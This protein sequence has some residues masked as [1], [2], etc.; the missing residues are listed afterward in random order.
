MVVGVAG[1]YLWGKVQ[2]AAPCPCSSRCPPPGWRGSHCDSRDHEHLPANRFALCPSCATHTDARH[3][4]HTPLHFSSSLIYSM[5]MFTK[6]CTLQLRNDCK[7]NCEYISNRYLYLL[8]LCKVISTVLKIHLD[9]LILALL[10][11]Y[12]HN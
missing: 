6:H 10:K 3:S 9:N 2:K 7:S 5:N 12:K 1:A 8:I 4:S 11:H